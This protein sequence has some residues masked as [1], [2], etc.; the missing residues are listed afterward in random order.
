MSG[1]WTVRV[2]HRCR[3]ASRMAR[4]GDLKHRREI[5]IRCGTPDCDWGT[6]FFGFGAD[7]VSRYQQ[8]FRKHCIK[9]HGLRP[10]AC[11]PII[12][13]NRN[14]AGFSLAM[15]TVK[16]IRARRCPSRAPAILLAGR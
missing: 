13:Q 1:A 3:E 12:R 11:E 4:R 2:V 5:H 16:L 6:P 15:E 9:H 7:H 8:L 10:D 14:Y